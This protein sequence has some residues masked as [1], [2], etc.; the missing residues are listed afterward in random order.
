[1]ALEYTLSI[2][3]PDAVRKR[4]IGQIYSRF[5]KNALVVVIA[6]RVR[7]TR[8]QAENFYNVH[9]ERSFFPQLVAFMSSGPIMV[10][11]LK[12]ESAVSRNR[13]IM[14]D[15]DPRRAKPGTL[16][17]DFATTIEENAVHGSDSIETAK[18]EIAFFFPE[19]SASCK[20]HPC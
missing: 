11:V 13:E 17:A 10:Q 12:A 9:K 14:G 15:T 5:E 2:I 3:K 19:F 1:M 20:D 8:E 18:K 7:L 16:R 4:L 6:K